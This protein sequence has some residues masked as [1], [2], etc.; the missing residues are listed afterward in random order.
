MKPEIL[1]LRFVTVDERFKAHAERSVRSFAL[2]LRRLEAG[3]P[4]S[5]T[6]E[7]DGA[8]LTLDARAG[9]SDSRNRPSADLP[10]R[11]CERAGSARKRS[12]RAVQKSCRPCG[13]ST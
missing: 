8:N 3:P 10:D 6:G 12:L 11:P 1:R 5:M 4:S 7:A 9:R 13:N 2:S